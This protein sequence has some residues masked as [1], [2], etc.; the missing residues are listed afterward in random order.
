V[1]H[2]VVMPAMEMDQE[3][4]TLLQWLKAPGDIVAAGEPLMEIETDKVTVDIESDV[5]GVLAEVRA[6]PGD[7]IAVGTVIALIAT[8]TNSGGSRPAEVSPGATQKA[9]PDIP[10]P[11]EASGPD[12]GRQVALSAMQRRVAH[13]VQQSYQ[14]APHIIVRR[15]VEFTHVTN[16]LNEPSGASRR[17]TILAVLI[18]AMALALRVHTRLNAH[19][20]R[21]ELTVYSAAHIGVAV[22]V[23]G[24]LIVPVVRH[25]DSKS[26]AD[27]AAEVTNLSAKARAGALTPDEVGGSTCTISNLGMFEVDDFTAILNPP[28]VAILAVGR[29][30][31]AAVMSRQD[32]QLAACPVLTLSLSV[33]HRAVNGTD[34]AAFMTTLARSL[35]TPTAVVD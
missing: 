29:V 31:Q 28:E 1:P 7:V 6:Q 17:G 33:D 25:A 16:W 27:I 19:Y 11:A 12:V 10:A 23:E 35:E 4:A 22:A 18:K 21:D 20:E 8:G 14:S 32:G 26:V 24:G 3:S 30:R 5:D 2:E 15:T 13:R 34:A 9:A